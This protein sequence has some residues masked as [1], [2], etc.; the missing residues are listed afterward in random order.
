M[1]THRSRGASG[2]VIFLQTICVLTPQQLLCGRVAATAFQYRAR[3][4]RYVKD[5]H[6]A[7]AESPNQ[8]P[9]TP[10]GC[11]GTVLA[12][13]KRKFESFNRWRDSYTSLLLAVIQV[14]SKCRNWSRL[15][16][17]RTD[18]PEQAP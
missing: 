13:P 7:S 5:A 6:M 15:H 2:G 11:G 14:H 4:H 1:L 8:L 10:R 12:H 17:H 3:G 9:D 18:A 16:T